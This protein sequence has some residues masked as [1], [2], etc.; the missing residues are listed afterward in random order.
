MKVRAFIGGAGC[1]KTHLLMQ[2]LTAQLEVAPLIEGQKVLALTFMHGSRR[3]LEERL[4]QLP[5]L[6]GRAECTTVDSFAFRL[7]RRWRALAAQLGHAD[8]DP[9]QYDRM[10]DAAGDLLQV[11]E[12]QGWVAASFPILLVDEA[13]DLTVNRLR[14]IQGL[15]ARLQLFAAADEFQ[16]LDERLRPN[17]ACTWLSQV[18]TA[19]ELTQPRRTNVTELLDAA[20]AIRGGRSPT[21]GR[22]F[23]VH[24]TPKPQLAGWWIANNLFWSGG[25]KCVAIITP[26]LGQFAES[27]VAWIASNRTSK[28]AGPYAVPWEKSGVDDASAFFKQLALQE[29]NHASD[30]SRLFGAAGDPWIA[31][32]VTEWM[33]MQRRAKSKVSFSKEEVERVVS[34]VFAQRRRIGKSDTRGWRGMTVHGAKNREFDNVIVLWPARTAGSDDQKRRLL[35]NAVTRA[36]SRCIVL[37]QAKAHLKQAP[38]V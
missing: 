27:A 32:D 25:G 18:C 16:C 23:S 34:Q 12:V 36:M 5:A 33:E 26:S 17:P 3:R 2:S 30:L 13:Q 7:A 4:R 28:G 37:V 35:Y 11:R 29:M 21:S 6:K 9:S 38:F 24:L 10:C 19:E 31:R 15:A 1:G 20:A 8:I 14:L 22:Q